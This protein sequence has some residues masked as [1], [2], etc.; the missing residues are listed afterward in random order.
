LVWY[1]NTFILHHY[2]ENYLYQYYSISHKQ[3]EYINKNRIIVAYIDVAR[4]YAFAGTWLYY[5]RQC[6]L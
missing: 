2:R 4:T 6:H 5:N 1:S 3:I